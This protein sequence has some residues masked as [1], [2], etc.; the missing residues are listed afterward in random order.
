MIM[1]NKARA[2]LWVK[3]GA[4]LITASFVLALMPALSAAGLGDMF[5]SLFQGTSGSSTETQSQAAIIKLKDKLK[6]NPK[7][8]A[9]LVALGNA[10]YDLG[11]FQQAIT[12]YTQSLAIDPK[13]YDVTTDMGAAYN[14]LGQTDKALEIFKQV[15]GEKPDQAMAWYNMGVVYKAKND[16]PNMRFAWERFLAIQPTG[17]QADNVRSELS[18]SSSSTTGTS[19]Q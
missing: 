9:S 12:Y 15:T 2:S 16:T 8:V 1:L 18:A 5:K 19:G 7:D 17:T 14:A 13:N 3:I 6:S 11:K 10:Y 4:I